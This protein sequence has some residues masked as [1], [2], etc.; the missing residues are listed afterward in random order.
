MRNTL[1]TIFTLIIAASPLVAITALAQV[2]LRWDTQVERPISHAATCYQGETIQLMPRLMRGT[3]PETLSGTATFYWQAPGMAATWWQA[4]AALI[5]VEPGRATA[6]FSPAM[7]NGSPAYTWF[8]RI[9]AG[10]G[11]SYRAHGTI[12]MRPSPGAQPNHI[13]I[14]TPTIDFSQ[15]EI[16]NPPWP[17]PATTPTATDLQTATNHLATQLQGEYQ[18]YGPRITNL[19]NQTDTYLRANE[20]NTIDINFALEGTV[21]DSVN[22]YMTEQSWECVSFA[23]RRNSNPNFQWHSLLC[24]EYLAFYTE[25]DYVNY[26][27][28]ALYHDALYRGDHHDIAYP[29][30]AGPSSTIATHHD[31]TTA[32][33]TLA[34][35]SYVHTAISTITAPM[36]QIDG[37]Y[38]RQYWDTN[39][40]TTAWEPVP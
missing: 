27:G 31:I 19:E 13:P 33:A 23:R 28:I 3:T 9:D 37:T 40:L 38:Y 4:P 21:N 36:L 12:T 32:T 39:L 5:D 7:D 6:T 2:P 26:N 30:P 34:T 16:L 24:A 8:I 10:S 22:T 1:S 17:N 29:W 14:P 25:D 20:R 35:T 18:P 15:V 11:A